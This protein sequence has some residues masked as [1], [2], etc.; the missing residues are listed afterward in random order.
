MPEI[1][2]LGRQKPGDPRG[3]LSA[4]LATNW[5]SVR[6]A[7]SENKVEKGLKKIYPILTSD[8]HVHPRAHRSIGGVWM[9]TLR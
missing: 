9:I 5:R 8:L 6:V 3:S 1:P 2:A 4:S 7:G